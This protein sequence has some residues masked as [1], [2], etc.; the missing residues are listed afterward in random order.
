MRAFVLAG[1]VAWLVAGAAPARAQVTG[2]IIA[3]GETSIQRSG[4][5]PASGPVHSLGPVKPIR[6]A[7]YL[8][9]SDHIEAALCRHFGATIQVSAPNGAVPQRLQVRVRHGPMTREDGAMLEEDE[10]PTVVNDGE[11][12]S[13]FTFDAAYEMVPGEWVIGFYFKGVLLAAK[14]FVVTMPAPGHPVSICEALSS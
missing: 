13:G 4:S 8:N 11:T 5:E 3:F 9:G 12:Y 7:T 10:F 1:L 2:E 14:T 6:D